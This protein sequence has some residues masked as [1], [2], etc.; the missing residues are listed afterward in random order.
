M[1]VVNMTE[2]RNN[3]K[4]IFDRVYQNNEEIIVNRKNSE[5]VV[6]ISLDMY[7][8][9]KETDYLLRS[10]KNRQHLLSSIAEL[11]EGKVKEREI[12]E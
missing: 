7:N 12:I 1:E 5:N 8:S 11:K 6:I 3:L 2:A 4:S 10:D 9:L